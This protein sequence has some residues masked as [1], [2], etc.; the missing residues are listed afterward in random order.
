[1]GELYGAK[2]FGIQ[3]E[4]EGRQDHAG[5]QAWRTQVGKRCEGQEAETSSG[6]RSESGSQIRS[7]DSQEEKILSQ[8]H[9]FLEF[10]SAFLRW[11]GFNLLHNRLCRGDET[12]GEETWGEEA[13]PGAASGDGAGAEKASGEETGDAA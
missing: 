12:S 11:N 9:C 10:G 6:D 7:E 1:M 13:S 2:T 3:G 5:I 4:E 8:R